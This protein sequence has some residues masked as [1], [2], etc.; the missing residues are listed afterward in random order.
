MTIN[1]LSPTRE[2]LNEVAGVQDEMSVADMIGRCSEVLNGLV[3][4]DDEEDEVGVTIGTIETE[5]KLPMVGSDGL[6]GTM[7]RTEGVRAR[8]A[9]SHLR[10][11][12]LEQCKECVVV[13]VV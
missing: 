7:P 9:L 4:G 6:N 12:K 13:V 2:V 10:P 3:T 1:T 11:E 5:T 8:N